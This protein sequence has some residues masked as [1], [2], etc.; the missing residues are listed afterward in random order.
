MF[1][2]IT[3][4][5]EQKRQHS[6]KQQQEDGTHY[7]CY[8]PSALCL[9]RCCQP[10]KRYQM[11]VGEKHNLTRLPEKAKKVLWNKSVES[12]N[13]LPQQELT[14]R[15]LKYPECLWIITQF[16]RYRELH[17]LAC[18]AAVVAAVAVTVVV[19]IYWL[20]AVWKIFYHWNT[21]SDTIHIAKCNQDTA[22]DRQIKDSDLWI[23]MIKAMSWLKKTQHFNFQKHRH[24]SIKL[25]KISI[26]HYNDHNL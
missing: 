6:S 1:V 3:V 9:T 22:Q 13:W 20:I 5:P 19:V 15:T 16:G 25:R 10:G 24:L 7:S 11:R 4:P 18:L 21:I 26:K 12:V 2:C 8:C 14:G 17:C 23:S